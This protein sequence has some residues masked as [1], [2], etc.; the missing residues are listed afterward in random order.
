MPE[1]GGDSVTR[2][3]NSRSLVR[4]ER[5]ESEGTEVGK[6]CMIVGLLKAAISPVLIVQSA[7]SHCL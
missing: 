3:Q 4:S 2:L 1:V 7:I 5:E 6:D